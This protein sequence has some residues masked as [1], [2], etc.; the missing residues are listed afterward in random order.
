MR[1]LDKIHEVYNALSCVLFGS[2][3]TGNTGYG[4]TID[5]NGF[6]D[7]LAVVCMGNVSGTAASNGELVVKF[8]ESANGTTGFTD[9]TDG[10]I[11]GTM[12]VKLRVKGHTAGTTPMN[13]QTKLY[14]RMKDGTRKRY[15]RCHATM[16][17]TAS[18]GIFGGPINVAVL[19]GRPQ[20]TAYIQAP[21]LVASG[22]EG[23][24][25]GFTVNSYIP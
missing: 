2:D 11:N 13:Y 23:A 19:L 18:S 6:E 22:N 5:T 4:V 14:E 15:V 20:N 1:N 8:Q 3:S 21:S 24:W 25:V 16:L 12:Q 10:A 7:L 17:A 9:I